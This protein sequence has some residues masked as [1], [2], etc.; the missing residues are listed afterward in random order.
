LVAKGKEMADQLM[1]QINGIGMNNA[2]KNCD[3]FE[4]P[5]IYKIRKDGAVSNQDMFARLLQSEQMVFTAKG[6]S[7]YFG[8]PKSEEQTMH[9]LL[10]NVRSGMTMR[11]WMETFALEAYRA[12]PMSLIFMEQKSQMEVAEDSDTVDPQ[13]YPTYKSIYSIFDYQLEGR[14]VEYVCFSLTPAQALAFGVSDPT[15]SDNQPNILPDQKSKYYRFVDDAMDIILKLDNAIVSEATMVAGLQNPVMNPWNRCPAFIVSDLVEFND[16]YCFA[17]PLKKTVELANTFLYD[18]SVR[19]LQKRYHGFSKAV[20]PLMQCGTCMGLG[21]LQ[22]QPCPDCSKPGDTKGSGYKIKTKVSDV[23]RFPLEILEN[24]SFDF[25]KLFGYVTPDIQG[26]DKQDTSLEAL[27]N[28]INKTYWGVVE[29]KQT[30]GPSSGQQN[31]AE[32]ATKTLSNL[33]PKYAR[34]NKTADWAEVTE[35]MIAQF[36]GEFWFSDF[37]KA[38]IAYGRYYILET[39]DELASMYEDMRKAGA[40]IG[41]LNDA[42]E[43][44]FHSVYQ[45]DPVQL[46]VRIKLMHLEPF[47][48]MNISNVLAINPSKVDYYSKVYFSEWLQTKTFD[49]LFVTAEIVLK[50]DLIAFA[51]SKTAM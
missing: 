19:D 20:E 40:P 33:Q 30:S 32:T 24:T 26:W 35:S 34:L 22:N 38:A 13:V 7:A 5:D 31:I 28:L 14:K 39:P 21:L 50:N 46:V 15:L 51:Q 4:S 43:K 27:E 8:L 49:Q 29:G 12:D 18:R 16:P 42:L 6:G 11:K 25:K 41:M 17:S 37:K 10:E 48:H 1:L 44:Y 2:I 23:A 47:V 9:G 3:Y 45:S 36:I